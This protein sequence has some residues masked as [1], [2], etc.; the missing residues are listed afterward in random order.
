LIF[1]ANSWSW[2]IGATVLLGINQGLTWSMTI[3]AKLD[4]A[5]PRERG[6]ANGLNEF[7]GYIAVAAA[8]L[9]TAW[10]AER[11]GSRPA[12]LFFGAAVI[13]PALGIALAL[14][15]ETR[16]AELPTDARPSFWSII[17]ASWRDRRLLAI[18]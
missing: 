4:I 1:Y 3:T 15:R 14:V 12:L 17:H 2:I 5:A 6:L 7:F 16:P 13:I 10:L 8:G 9:A 18:C 11:I